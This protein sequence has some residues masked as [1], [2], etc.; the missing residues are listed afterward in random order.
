M[1]NEKI[2]SGM[3]KHKDFFR[4][5]MWRVKN[6]A[7]GF[8]DAKA[9]KKM[10]KMGFRAWLGTLPKPALEA[11]YSN[12]KFGGAVSRFDNLFG[13]ANSTNSPWLNGRNQY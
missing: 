7:Y 6:A 10:K 13:S 2:V 4:P 8:I 1:M 9:K 11:I 3:F 5:E 12:L